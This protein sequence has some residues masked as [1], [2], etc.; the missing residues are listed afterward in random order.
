[1]SFN[2]NISEVI[3]GVT[4]VALSLLVGSFIFGFSSLFSWT[5][6]INVHDTYY[7]VDSSNGF[8]LVLTVLAF[9][10]YLIRAIKSKF[11]NQLVNYILLLANGYLVFMSK[12]IAVISMM[13]SSVAKR[14]S[15]TTG[16]DFPVAPPY[17]ANTNAIDNNTVYVVV[18]Q[19]ALIILFGYIAYR[20][21]INN[22][23]HSA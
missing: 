22:V 12:M 1:M 18:F 6:D 3:W 2:K 21:G 4:I 20:T 5:T 8:L 17:G 15:D 16:Q 14:A 7:V 11:N 19:L 10:V 9:L 23:K 13:I